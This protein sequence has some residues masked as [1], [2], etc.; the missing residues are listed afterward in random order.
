MVEG[1]R[2]EDEEPGIRNLNTPSPDSL[3][4]IIYSIYTILLFVLI[5]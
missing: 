5:R 3:C 1:K 2:D 4:G